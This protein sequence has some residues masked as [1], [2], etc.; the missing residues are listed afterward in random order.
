[1]NNYLINRE[2]EL[3]I[4]FKGKNKLFSSWDIIEAY[5]NFYYPKKGSEN[6]TFPKKENDNKR[7]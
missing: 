5:M 2:F 3:G 1:M 4:L 6:G 7:V